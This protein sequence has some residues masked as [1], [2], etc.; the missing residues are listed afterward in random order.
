MPLCDDGQTLPPPINI[1]WE[2]SV[3]DARMSRLKFNCRSRLH[4]KLR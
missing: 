2:I 4:E 1:L 3:S